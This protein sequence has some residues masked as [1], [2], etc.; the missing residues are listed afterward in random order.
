[1]AIPATD[2]QSSPWLQVTGDRARLNSV[3]LAPFPQSIAAGVDSVMVAHVT[4][5]ALEREANRVATT[6]PAIV[7]DLLKRELGFQGIVVTDA[8]D[9]AGLTRLYSVNPGPR[10]GRCIQ[11]GQ[12]PAADSG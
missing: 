11:G 10:G 3:E 12:R 2:S 4:V 1:M 9:M 7:N 6:S 8:L 5:P